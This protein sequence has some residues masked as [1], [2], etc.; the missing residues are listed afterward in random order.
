MGPALVGESGWRNRG[1][2]GGGESEAGVG[3]NPDLHGRHL[4]GS[5]QEKTP[6]GFTGRFTVMRRTQNPDLIDSN[7]EIIFS[8]SSFVGGDCTKRGVV[9]GST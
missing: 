7:S 8:R 4:A 2:A 5:P 3:V 6:G 9:T 1:I